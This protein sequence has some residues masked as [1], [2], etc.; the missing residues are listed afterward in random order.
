MSDDITKFKLRPLGE[1]VEILDS[2]RKPINSDARRNRQGN[3]PY[4]GANGQAGTIDEWIFEEELVLVAED[5]GFF[6]D[7]FRPISYR[8]SGK[9]W[10]NNHAHVLRP[11]EF[12]DIDWLNYAIGYQDIHHLIKGATLKKLNQGD[13]KRILIPCPTLT[14]QYRIVA[15]IKECMERVEEIEALRKAVI[16]DSQYL[17]SA[18]FADYVESLDHSKVSES[19]LG[20]VVIDCKYGSSQKANSAGNGYPMLRMGNIQNGRLDTADLKYVNLSKNEQQKYALLDG[21]ILI[22]RT[23]SMELVGK[24]AVIEGLS[25]DWVY[26]SYLIRLRVD[27]TK[28][29]P[30]YVN[31]MINSR[32]GRYYV[33]RTARRAIGMVNINAQE[34]QRMPLPLLPIDEQQSLVDKM[35]ET[36]PIINELSGQFRADGITHLRESI[37]RKAFAGEL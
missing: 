10:V 21:D 20:D 37:L 19:V 13:L 1:C 3:I 14:E 18:V 35:N 6:D 12:V 28:A 9:S 4:Y 36:E 32:I 23:N 29:L 11:L 16:K 33:Y 26:A 2:M 17:P 7:P 5:G 27:K 22:N 31:A 30:T 15:R 34:I 25:G 24:S 8:I